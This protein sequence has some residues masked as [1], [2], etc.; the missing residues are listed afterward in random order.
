MGNLI[1]PMAHNGPP[2]CS[3]AADPNPP[4]NGVRLALFLLE[5]AINAAVL[6]SSVLFAL[7]L[8]RIHS[9]SKTMKVIFWNMLVAADGIAAT[10]SVI[11]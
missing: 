6:A 2:N 10:R 9:F 4:I 5:M 11:T 7:L 1:A 8:V 3:I